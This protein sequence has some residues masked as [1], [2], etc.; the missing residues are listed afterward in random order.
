MFSDSTG[1]TEYISRGGHNYVLVSTFNGYIHFEPMKTRHGLSYVAAFGG[2]IDYF[3]SHGHV[4]K[5]QIIDNETSTDVEQLI[6]LNKSITIQY[7]TV[8]NHR[9]N[10]AERAIQPG[11]NHLVATR[12]FLSTQT[13]LC[14]SNI[15]NIDVN[16]VPL[17]VVLANKT[18]MWSTG[19]ATL[20]IPHTDLSFDVHIFPDKIMH[21]SL[22]GI[23]SPFTPAGCDV[24]FQDTAVTIVQ[25]GKVIMR[26]HK[27]PQ[28]ELWPM[29][30]AIP[31]EDGLRPLPRE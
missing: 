27:R 11:K 26:E 2:T 5:V 19:K 12:Y 24:V 3:H 30:Q 22:Y 21:V 10:R 17:A 15:S 23:C 8:K 14:H 20:S 16:V 28:D 9:S 25:K 1:R 4:I 31:E 7:V 13:V 6:S 29:P 18:T